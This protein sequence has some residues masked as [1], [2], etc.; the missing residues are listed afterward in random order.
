MV[1][2]AGP[3]PAHEVTIRAARADD[4]RAIHTLH[5]RYI[6][7]L[8]AGLLGEYVPPIAERMERARGWAGPIGSPHPRHAL[9]VAERTQRV[10]G[11]V[12]AGP[13]RDA[14]EDTATTGE[15]RVIVVDAGERRAGV[16]AALVGAGEC[17]MREAGLSAATLW[18]VRDNAPA[19]RC[20]ER[21]G[22]RADGAAKLLELGGRSVGAIRYGKRLAP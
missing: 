13:T 5:A 14:G 21:C 15:L 10:I 6:P 22:W 2:S 16:G 9:L 1:R 19:V 8:F 3:R 17:A 20:Y 7:D 12:V 4:E 11:F 18:V